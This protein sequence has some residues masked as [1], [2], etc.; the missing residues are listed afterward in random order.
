MGTIQEAVDAFFERY[1]RALLDHDAKTLAGLYAVPSLSYLPGT[2]HSGQRGPAD[3]G[4]F[5]VRVGPV[6]GNH[7]T[8]E[9]ARHSGRGTGK[10]LGRRHLVLRRPTPERFCYQ[11]VHGPAGYQIAV[12]TLM[13]AD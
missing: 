1:A 8:R 4:V 13:A 12:L 9:T 7:P 2:V 10:R 6:R 3:G 11:L 5:R